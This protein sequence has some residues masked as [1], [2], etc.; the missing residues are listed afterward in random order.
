MVW[1]LPVPGGMFS[2]PKRNSRRC[3]ASR[4]SH[5]APMCQ[6]SWNGSAGSMRPQKIRTKPCSVLQAS[7]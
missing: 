4:N 5:T 7:R 3:Q 1:L 6:L 2:T